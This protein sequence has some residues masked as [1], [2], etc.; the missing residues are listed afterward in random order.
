M[1]DKDFTHS[2]EH[3]FLKEDIFTEQLARENNNLKKWDQARPFTNMQYNYFLWIAPSSI[4]QIEAI[5]ADDTSNYLYNWRNW[6]GNTCNL[7]SERSKPYANQVLA[8][9]CI[10]LW[11]IGSQVPLAFKAK[12]GEHF[13]HVIFT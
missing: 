12:V 9:C 8:Q 4:H 5:L 10:P 6:Q 1:M 7:K 2:K 13:K 11:P 3:N